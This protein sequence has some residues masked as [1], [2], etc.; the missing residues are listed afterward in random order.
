MIPAKCCRLLLNEETASTVQKAF[1]EPAP[2]VFGTL[3]GAKLDP[4]TGAQDKSVSFYMEVID[5]A[6]VVGNLIG[7][8]R[9][10]VVKNHGAK[11]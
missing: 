2:G 4:I 5:V 3:L 7:F 6:F 1:I 11:D 9:V 10:V 8:P